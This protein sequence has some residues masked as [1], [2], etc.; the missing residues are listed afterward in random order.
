M[1]RSFVTCA[2]IVAVF[3]QVHPGAAG[4]VSQNVPVPGGTAAMAQSLR[5]APPPDRARFVAELARLTHPS[6]E[7]A[8]TT[9][10]RMAAS[11]G[12]GAVD[13]ALAAGPAETV[14]IPLTV[15]TWS[16]VVF[17]RAIAPEAIVAAILA[18]SRAAHLSYGLAAADDETLQYLA[19][20]PVLLKRLYEHD[21]AVFA[22][23]GGSLRIRA[24]RV[25]PAGGAA[26]AALW[27]S[28]VG[29]RLDQPESFLPQLYG[30]DDG[31]LA[32]LYD[33]IAAMDPPRAAFALGLW[34]K[35]LAARTKRFRALALVN[36]T[37]FPQWQP[38]KLPF[39]RP[40]HDVGSMLARIQADPDGSPSFPA[41]RSWWSWAFEGGELPPPAAH[42]ETGHPGADD[43]IDAAWLAEAIASGDTRSRSERLDQVAFGQRAFGGADRG[44]VEDVMTAIRAFPRYRM[45]LLTLEQIGVRHAAVYATAA[46][47]AQ[48]LSPLDGGRAFA[49]LGQFQG[50][51]ALIAR[52]A[53]MRTID[54]AAAETLVISLSGV[55]INQDGRYGGGVATWL[56]QVL[57]PALPA[58]ADLDNALFQ[59]LA[60]APAAAGGPSRLIEWEGQRYRLDPAVAEE[61]R[62]RRVRDKQQ[63]ASLE[64]ALGVL[65]ISRAL[66]AAPV[67]AS[68]LTAAIAALKELAAAFGP[69]G[70]GADEGP[71]GGDRPPRDVVARAIEDLTGIT[72]PPDRQ[73][74]AR[75]GASLAA[76]VDDL[77]AEALMAWAY[78]IA[79]ADPASPVLLTGHITR[80][81]D[82]GLGPAERGLRRRQAW[83][84]PR[85]AVIA[86]TP[87]HISGSLLGLEVA[88][89]PLRRVNGERVIDPPTLSA[90]ERDTF[91]VSVALL[92]PLALRDEDGDA[93]VEAVTR[94][95]RRVAGL[96][97]DA[98]DFD[99][100][101]GEI[102]LDGRRRRAL[103]WTIVNEP[104]RIGS[105][106]SLTE[107]LYLGGGP[108]ASLNSWGTSA[109][110][111]SGC[112]CTRLAPPQLWRLLAGRP[113]LGLMA[114]AVPDLNLH[115]AMMLRELHL[116][117]G[118][119]RVILEAATQDFI[120]EVRPTDF[121]DWLTLV[122]TARSVSRERIEDYV[123][124]ATAV[125]PLVPDPT[126]AAGQP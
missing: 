14:P 77:T 78:A 67:A 89:S 26:A 113:Q 95:G 39:T 50:A 36:Q 83:G 61:Q 20:H 52:L 118:V 116:P 84:V 32:Y 71:I 57:R 63:G 111:W 69:R 29:E 98:G 91:A 55:P 80:R 40:L 6:S 16:R 73:K 123:A 79:I 23:F 31:R 34:I 108:V 75:T 70:D 15:E 48:Q 33:T 60:G 30:R 22:G 3:F 72:A 119:A 87:W 59:A 28:V 66:S 114:V 120:D 18:D 97:G 125:G 24:N 106:F 27:E 81:H 49:A 109:L 105:M 1:E 47:R 38:T 64:Q 124:T 94:G 104:Q 45:L 76:I 101:A 96:A 103:Q 37:A 11:L 117:A 112:L 56:Q 46:R 99:R 68:D 2:T 5:I 13:Q 88:L 121:N 54:A 122:R 44:P 43:P 90:N 82:F 12:R 107:L 58:A 92:D 17:R 19:D 62:L 25:V 41:R 42:P 21:A 8:S 100:I 10:A 65:T 35:D 9:R 7:A 53:R 74:A 86:R 93:I 4:G 85:A 115:V 51:L 102:E 126:G 110:G